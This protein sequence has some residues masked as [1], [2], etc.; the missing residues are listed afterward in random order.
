MNVIYLGCNG[1]P[2][3][4][5]EVQKQKMISKALISAGARVTII[6]SKGL[7][8]K[9]DEYLPY[10][11]TIENINYY[12]ASLT[13]YRHQNFFFRNLL[14]IIGRIVEF[15]L[16]ANLKRRKDKNIAIITTRNIY[17][18]MYYNFVLRLCG[19]KII[20]SYEEFIKN[21][22]LENNK[23]GI[24]LKFDDLVHKY[25]DAVLPIS[26][27]LENYQ[28]E[29]DKDLKTFKIPALTDFDLIDSILCPVKH[30]NT[31]L[32]CG[33]SVYF[34]NIRFIIDSFE[35]VKNPDAQLILI[36]HGDSIQNQIIYTYIANHSSK[37]DKIILLSNLSYEELIKNYKQASVLLIPL[38]PYER[39]IARFPHKIA[40]Y[41]ASKTP[42]LT[43]AVGEINH[44]FTDNLNAF[45]ADEYDPVLFGRKIDII[46]KEKQLAGIV[47]T[48]AYD[49][50]RNHF[51]YLSLSHKLSNFIESL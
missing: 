28:K 18:L 39:D 5:A 50:G 4:F 36:I 9:S 1:F 13:P 47:A 10:K 23:K 38:K 25:C 41:T 19:Y 2:F 35:N 46:L 29:Q 15:I 11:G 32:F 24:H 34:E 49:L 3:G 14:K 44:Y 17:T 26:T 30:E 22:N 33:A 40:E 43:T 31:V 37:S 51:H 12:N 48:N 7:L 27:F 42:V 6:N 20:L 45:I 8:D 16:I 21:I